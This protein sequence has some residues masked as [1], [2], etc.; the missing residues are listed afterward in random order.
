MKNVTLTPHIAS[1]SI[2]T[3]I[4]MAVIVAQNLLAGLKGEKMSNPVQ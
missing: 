3:R 2:D 1:A 4:K